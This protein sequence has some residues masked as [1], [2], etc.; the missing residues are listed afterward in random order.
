MNKLNNLDRKKL[1]AEEVAKHLALA[2][3]ASAQAKGINDYKIGKRYYPK[4]IL[5]EYYKSS[6]YFNRYKRKYL[7]INEAIKLIEMINDENYAQCFKKNEKDKNG[8]RTVAYHFKVRFKHKNL[9]FR[10]HVRK[11]DEN[12]IKQIKIDHPFKYPNETNNNKAINTVCENMDVFKK[13]T[14]EKLELYA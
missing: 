11:Q 10:F 8:Q 4:E 9:T 1:L 2:C 3:I 13:T 14:L 5:K 7:E 12:I 6:K